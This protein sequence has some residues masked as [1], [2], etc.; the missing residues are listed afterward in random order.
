MMDFN[1][2]VL[3]DYPNITAAEIRTIIT[4]TVLLYL[5]LL[6]NSPSLH[7]TPGSVA[8]LVMHVEPHGKGFKRVNR[9]FIMVL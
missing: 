1:N 2:D 3:Q 8:V 7:V 6:G 4:I 9:T 5:N